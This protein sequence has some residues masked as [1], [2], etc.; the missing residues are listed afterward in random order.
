MDL[1]SVPVLILAGGLGTRLSEETLLIPKPMV[2]VGGTP[3][4]VH[5]MRWY[6]QFGFRE[7]VL[8]AGYKSEAIKQY[9]ANYTLRQNHVEIDNLNSEPQM[10]VLGRQNS[11]EE[12]WRVRII[13]TGALTMTG[14]RVARA[15]DFLDH[16]SSLS[17]DH[18]ALTYGDGLTDCRLDREFDFHLE[19]GRIGTVLGVHP[20]ARFG[21]LEIDENNVVTEF[22]EKPKAQHDFINGGFFFFQKSFRKYLSTD[23]GSILERAPLINLARDKQL[24]VFKHEG[25]WHPMDTMRD[26]MHLH[27]LWE[28]GDAP[29]KVEV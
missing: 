29:W 6:Y 19:H 11:A 7:F 26:K 5:L 18:F 1:K 25:F 22:Q 10:R 3:I 4:L 16:D 20:V 24:K 21:E 12:K 27:D 14:G 8:C 13:D 15:L 28:Q 23:E 17:F 2:E 9:F